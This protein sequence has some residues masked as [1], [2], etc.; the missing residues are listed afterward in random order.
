MRDGVL[1]EVV[2]QGGKLDGRAHAV[3]AQVAI[4]MGV[5]Q[6]VSP[7]IYFHLHEKQ[8]RDYLGIPFV[9]QTVVVELREGNGRGG[10]SRVS[11]VK[12]PWSGGGRGFIVIVMVDATAMG[13]GGSW[14]VG[15]RRLEGPL[16]GR[17]VDHQLE[18]L[19]GGGQLG[20]V[21]VWVGTADML[22]HGAIPFFL[23][24]VSIN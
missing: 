7:P 2:A 19:L 14:R 21:V 3:S 13:R 20:D 9:A 6:Q 5:L 1:L 18:A 11:L 23:G 12:S 15:R 17:G 10:S 16:V 8:K 22:L 4:R 24:V